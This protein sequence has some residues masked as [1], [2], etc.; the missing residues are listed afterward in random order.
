MAQMSSTIP[1]PGPDAPHAPQITARLLGKD[2]DWEALLE[3]TTIGPDV[4]K[5]DKEQTLIVIVQDAS[6]AI[7]QTWMALTV[8]HVEG[9]WARPDHEG[10]AGSTRLLIDKMVTELRAR[11]VAEVLTRAESGKIEVLIT[12]IGGR[13]VPGSLWAIPI[14]EQ[15]E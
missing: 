13:R 3:G 1:P 12:K 15:Q 4:H 2:E 6:G 9:L 10:H 8:V 7:V 11:N 14:A 5:L